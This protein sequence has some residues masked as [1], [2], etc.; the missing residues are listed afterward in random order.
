MSKLEMDK[1]KR[2]AFIKLY[3]AGKYE[4]IFKLF[5][6]SSFD[7]IEQYYTIVAELRQGYD[8]FKLLNKK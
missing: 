7:E 8:E 1:A 4:D 5:G 2:Q 6:E 3:V